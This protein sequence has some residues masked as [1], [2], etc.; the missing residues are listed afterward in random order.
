MPFNP[1]FPGAMV[2][3]TLDKG[4]Y[5]MYNIGST[6]TASTS[7]ADTVSSV[8]IRNVALQFEAVLHF[9]FDPFLGL[10]LRFGLGF[11]PS[12]FENR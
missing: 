12:F 6:A 2:A 11:D 9:K 7:Q 1:C 5:R 10:E 3:Q 8:P 4:V